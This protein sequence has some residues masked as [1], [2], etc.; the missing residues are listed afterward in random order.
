A[1]RVAFAGIQVGDWIDPTG[2]TRD[3]SVRLQA[4]DRVDAANIER[5]P[6]TVAG[7]GQMV[8]LGQI[9]TVTMGKGPAGIQH[10][11][12]KRTVGVSANV[13]GRAA[14]EVSADAL[15]LAKAMSFPPG[16]GIKL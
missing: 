8:P 15:K 13:Q 9:A 11:D 7:T 5:L 1:L 14:G 6:I 3:V 2:K 4:T 10:L 16:Y 12:G